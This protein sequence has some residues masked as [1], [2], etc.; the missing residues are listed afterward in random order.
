MLHTPTKTLILVILIYLVSFL[1]PRILGKKITPQTPFIIGIVG[2]LYQL[3]VNRAERFSQLGFNLSPPRLYV[4][5]FLAI[6]SILLAVLVIGYAASKL[7]LRQTMN[8]ASYPKLFINLLLQL[9]VTWI[10]ATFIEELVFRGLVQRQLHQ[11]LSPV[12]AILVAST[13]FGIWH[14]PFGRLVKLNNR[15]LILYVLGTGLVG[16][17]FGTFYYQSQSLIV[18]GFVHGVWNSIV[19]T[20]WGLGRQVPSLLVSQDESITHPEYGIV[21]VSALTI[22]VITLFLL[23]SLV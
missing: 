20:T 23:T 1:P 22:A 14:I 2:I 19:Y 4:Q 18:A 9:I 6:V 21:G 13:A 7:N 17:V 12:P 5:G 10:G 3:I 8:S 16:V 15:Q 11:S